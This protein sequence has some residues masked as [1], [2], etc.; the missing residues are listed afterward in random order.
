MGGCGGG[1]MQTATGTIKAP[2]QPERQRQRTSLNALHIFVW[3]KSLFSL[4]AL[5]AQL[6]CFGQG[7]DRY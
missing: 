4:F 7:I 5:R 1:G 6:D 2:R 3:S